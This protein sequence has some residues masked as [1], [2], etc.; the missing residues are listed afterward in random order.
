MTKPVFVS[1]AVAC[2][3]AFA[4]LPALAQMTCAELGG[5]LA[6]QQHV[7]P[8]M[9]STPFT[10]LTS[11]GAN[12]RCEANFI[13]SSRGGPEF[14]YD[15]GEQQRV[16][17]RVGLPLNSLEG[18]SGGVEGMGAWNGRTRAL[19][20]GGCAGSVGGVTTATSRRYVG[21]STD[22]GH[23]GGDCLFALQPTPTRLNVGRLN[24]FIVDSLVA[25]VRWSKTIAAAY[26]NAA[27]AR[28]YWDGCSTGGRQG[29]ALAQR[30]PEELDGWLLGA[31]AVNYGRFR[32]AQLW[33]PI[34]MRELTGGAISSAKTAQATASAIA[35]CDAND[36][37]MDSVIGEP[38]GCTFSAHANICGAPGAPATNCLTREEAEAIDLIWDGPRNSH[39]LQVF[40]GLDRGAQISALNGAAPSPTATS[41][42]RW[43][44]SDASVDWTTLTLADYGREAEL[45]SNTTGDIIN[46]MD[47]KLE[48]VR[49]GGKKILMWHGTADQLITAE[50]GLE[51]YTRA[52]A[53]F[54]KG[55]PDFA[56]LQSWFRY[57]RMPGV[58]HCGGG[59]GPQ[60]SQDAMF[61]QMVDWVENGVA[62]ETVPTSGGGRT[63]MACPFPQEAIYDGS[64]NP[65]LAS[66]WK[67]GGNVQTKGNICQSIVT[68]Y[69]QESEN[70]LQA[71]GKYNAAACNENS[72]VPLDGQANGHA[73]VAA[74][75]A[76]DPNG[77]D[78]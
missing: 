61:Q 17:I 26:Y 66:S 23:V 76:P 35:A 16:Q 65:N 67:C 70:K 50:N 29:F 49:D 62:P 78:Q 21:S 10:T 7:L 22:T 46:T 37:V 74:D 33:G 40:P 57:F 47:V 32:L 31:P 1:A 12:A 52:A 13:F 2:T 75:Y 59:P 51:Y 72:K 44:H 64:G 34:A 5:W 45:G 48:R 11:T 8:V 15:A 73:V 30:F 60:P 27:P 69:K 53:H 68:P 9:A 39:G 24:D 25:Q 56:V 20:G 6:A 42:L 63:R 71:W 55:T 28:N 19:G 41:Q 43:N 38:R 54:G 4:S 18:G 58:A 3:A 77:V 14:G 36:G